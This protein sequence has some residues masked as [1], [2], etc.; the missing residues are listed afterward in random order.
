LL[1]NPSDIYGGRTLAF[2]FE[3]FA[4]RVTVAP[5]GCVE[6]APGSPHALSA[7]TLDEVIAPGVPARQRAGTALLAAALRV[8]AA[9]YSLPQDGPRRTF[10][11]EF[12][13]SIPRQVGLGGSSAIVIAALRALAEWFSLPLDAGTL[14]AMALRAETEELG[15]TAGPMDRVAQAYEGLVYADFGRGTKAPPVAV[16]PELLPPVFLAWDPEPGE[17][18]GT[19]H[20]RVRAR[21]ESGDV[22][23]VA[24]VERLAALADEGLAA[25]RARDAGRFRAA[26]DESR[27]VRATVWTLGKRDQGL[28]A[29]GAG[30]GAAVKLCGSGGAIV[31]VMG[32][33]TEYPCVA[34]AYRAAGFRTLAPRIGPRGY[35]A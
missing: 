18:S 30:L 34:D 11:L 9:Q 17:P 24:A 10:R 27:E 5:S 29:V 12:A 26:L 1:G 16:D 23:M 35:G 25:L 33:Q 7:A 32:G 8:L 15:I 13:S 20:D 22:A 2:T 19:V 6:L 31:G 21:W 28:L 4:A 14:A 3:D